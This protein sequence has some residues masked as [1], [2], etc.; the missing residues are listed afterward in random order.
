LLRAGYYNDQH[1]QYGYLLYACAVLAREPMWWARW[2]EP[3]LHLVRAIAN[4]SGRDGLYIP[5]RYMDVYAG[6]SWASGLVS[7]QW[8]QPGRRDRDADLQWLEPGTRDRD[9]D[10][11][12]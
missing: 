9:A 1:F 8:L 7:Y 3:I 11:V 5:V 12:L 6:H 2:R 4:P 10:L